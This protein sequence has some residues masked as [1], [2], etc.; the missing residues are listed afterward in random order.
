MKI[1]I[2]ILI[3]VSSSLSGRVS[4]SDDLRMRRDTI[5]YSTSVVHQNPKYPDQRAESSI[6]VDFQTNNQQ[7]HR[8]TG[9]KRPKS[10]EQLPQQ[11]TFASH[12]YNNPQYHQ[13][14]EQ[15][16]A[17]QTFN[18]GY[19]VSFN[20]KSQKSLQQLFPPPEI[21]TGSRNEAVQR[22]MHSN[23]DAEDFVSNALLDIKKQK[24][25][26]IKPK[27]N[28]VNIKQDA[29]NFI[30]QLAP[31][32]QQYLSYL[33]DVKPTPS[34]NLHFRQQLETIVPTTESWTSVS[35]TVE[36]YR[37]KGLHT[38][39]NQTP[40]HFDH[41]SALGNSEGFD[42][43]NIM[44]AYDKNIKMMQESDVPFENENTAAPYR[45]FQ[46]IP[47]QQL[48]FAQP[49][50]EP[51]QQRQPPHKLPVDT[52]LL[53]DPVLTVAG[54]NLPT[55]KH[56]IPIP[57]DTSL[58][59]VLHQKLAPS[60]VV[61]DM[62]QQQIPNHPVVQQGN[63]QHSFLNNDNFEQYF[64]HHLKHVQP[65]ESRIESYAIPSEGYNRKMNIAK[66]IEMDLRPPPVEINRNSR[67]FIS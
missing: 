48:D 17:P 37:S 43:S 57:F 38:N 50:S 31:K 36:I 42:F 14:S 58:I 61:D 46:V 8:Q 11:Q 67:L 59:Q 25:S 9:R 1:L 18:V 28:R 10:N 22:P 39:I 19:S 44:D 45:Q 16:N 20:G 66:Y 3:C 63:Q 23:F 6:K 41:D 34:S 51:V 29:K 35:P 52:S 26:G 21:I 33:G 56:S 49:T 54:K 62:R 2:G 24:I 64:N 60:V 15:Y 7:G 32:T 4:N 13:E 40:K 5:G 27:Y 47:I 12:S 55:N 65:Q 53:R 30:T